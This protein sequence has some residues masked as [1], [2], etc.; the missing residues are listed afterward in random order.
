MGSRRTIDDLYI[1][2]RPNSLN[3]LRLVLAA[4]V[5]LWHSYAVLGI[6]KP[7]TGF[8]DLVGALPVNGFFAIS[9][10]LIYRSWAHQPSVKNYLLARVMRIYPAFWVCLIVTAV[11]FAPLS[12]LFQGGDPLRQLMSTST[13]TY[14]VKNASLAM[15]QWR[16]GNSPSD[17][18]FVDSW[19]A[20]LWTL[21]WE[22]LCYLGLL[23]LALL[24]M[25]T[26]K[27][28]LPT[29]FTASVIINVLA[30]SLLPYEAVG[31]AG[32]FSIFFLAGALVAQYSWRVTAGW[33][34]AIT[35]LT[36]ACLSSWIPVGHYIVQAPAIA[37]GLIALGGVFNPRWS[38]LRNDVSYGV[39]IYA[40]PVQQF[41]A[42]VGLLALDV[43]T[44]SALALMLTIPLALLSWFL[45]ERPSLRLRSTL[46]R[47]AWFR[48]RRGSL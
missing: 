24:G 14:L 32:R 11:I 47:R 16:I 42:I 28:I 41:L 7:D 4:A 22:F 10:F 48:P 43:L 38:E 17:I 13:L 26:R 39:Y 8:Q 25:T 31:R 6:E 15:F 23:G 40:F 37:I 18:P 33:G 12:T 29:A 34:V 1:R 27:W 3:L 35:A 19:D 44:F 45:I 30:M 5:I 2:S 46:G 9:G 21:A 36:V 20:S